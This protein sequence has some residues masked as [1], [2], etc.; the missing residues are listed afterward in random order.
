MTKTEARQRIDQLKIAIDHHRYLYH[1]LDRQ[2]IS[3]AALDSLKHELFLLEQK[4][5]ELITSDSPT[6]RVGGKPLAKFS[7]VRH[8]SRMLSMEDIFSFEELE[9]WLTRIQKLTPRRIEEFYCEMK[10][11]GLAMSLVYEDSLLV[12]G[13]TRG[14]GM[15]GEDILQNLKTIEAIPLRLHVP[16]EKEV[17]AF[18]ERHRAELDVKKFRHVIGSLAGRI[19]V[20]GEVFM[21]KPMFEAL[22]R[23]QENAGLPPF[24]NPRNAAAGAVRQLDPE[25]TRSRRLDF[26]G[27]ALIVDAGLT[28][29]AQ[30]HQFLQLI[31]V[32]VNPLSKL[33]R[34]TAE[35]EK[36]HDE[37]GKKREKLP[38]WTDGVVVVVN[39]D[40]IYDGLG[41]V[42]KTPR[43]NVAYKFPAEQATTV[44]EEIRVQVGRT[45]ALT[46]VAVMQPVRVAGTTVT[47]ATLHNEDEIER[48]GV[49]IGDTVVIEKAGDVIPKVIKVIIEARNGKEKSFRMPKKCPE[50][51]SPVTRQE[52]E[53]AAYCSNPHCYARTAGSI[54]HFVSKGGIDMPGLGDKIVERFLD[55]GLI[56]DAADLYKLKVE[57]L[58]GL[59]GFGDVSAKKMIAMIQSRR[60]V[61]LARLLYGL[62]IRHVGVE[63]ALDLAERF[64][65]IDGVRRA[66][67]ED[68]AAVANVGGVIAKSVH[69]WFADRNHAAYL[70]RLLAEVQV[71]RA[72]AA[73]KGPLTGKT[74]VLT[75]TLAS[76]GRDQA[77]TQIRALGGEVSESVSVKTSF[78]VAGADPGSKRIKAE[79]LGVPILNEQR[80]LDMLG[81]SKQ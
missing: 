15:V 59:E 51:G 3:E 81:G 2:E 13:A 22:N 6:Q 57:D 23:A 10:M 7:K 50:C 1:V 46:P 54:L 25:I 58:A 30:A 74:F 73:A 29:H 53:V 45:G 52:G 70:D 62:G 27:Y 56:C 36:Y 9:D 63:T 71:E 8:R 66:G 32:K 40:G 33:V 11:D 72:R 5:P 78:L 48:L 18:I 69:A 65:T 79:K 39:R 24:A 4:F 68:L 37:V 67:E 64:H 17:D 55:E 60:R 34:S 35:I 21:T 43:G 20:R 41:V 12:S 75:G 61:P 31:G 47:H 77:K 19:E 44:I 14:D 28:T 38:Y 42:G 26:F 80:F 16:E 49:R 76:L